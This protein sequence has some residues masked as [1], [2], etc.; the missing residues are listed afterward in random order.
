[1][2][3]GNKLRD[4]SLPKGKQTIICLAFVLQDCQNLFLMGVGW[5]FRK[6]SINLSFFK[7]KTKIKDTLALLK[8]TIYYHFD[9]AN[10]HVKT[11]DQAEAKNFRKQ[12]QSRN[13]LTDVCL[14]MHHVPKPKKDCKLY[15]LV[16][17]FLLIFSVQCPS[18]DLMSLLLI[19]LG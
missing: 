6:V 9:V 2:R 8:T 3:V 14:S 13:I 10:P 18:H 15:E 19:A 1:M 5:Q 17:Y 7:W 4:Y 12:E 16:L 11:A